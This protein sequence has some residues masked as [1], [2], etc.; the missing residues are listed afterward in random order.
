MRNTAFAELAIFK[1]S[2]FCLL[3]YLKEVIVLELL[4]AFKEN[5]EI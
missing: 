3:V 5:E 1:N 4:S 2:I